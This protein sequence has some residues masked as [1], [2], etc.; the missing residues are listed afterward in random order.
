MRAQESLEAIQAELNEFCQQNDYRCEWCSWTVTIQDET[1]WKCVIRVTGDKPEPG[2]IKFYHDDTM[3]LLNGAPSESTAFIAVAKF[4]MSLAKG[5]VSGNEKRPPYKKK[6][7]YESRIT[8]VN[9]MDNKP[10][11]QEPLK[12]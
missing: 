7:K 3:V 9:R 5:L 4:I 8:K 6:L 2:L 12:E 11:H 1:R 10:R